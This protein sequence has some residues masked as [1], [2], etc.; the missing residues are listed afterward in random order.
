M[1]EASHN[2]MEIL[3][4]EGKE[5]PQ[6]IEKPTTQ[7]G[8]AE[9]LDPFFYRGEFRAYKSKDL[10]PKYENLLER[11]IKNA[12]PLNQWA[13][14]GES[15][16]WPSWLP[17]KINAVG[18]EWPDFNNDPGRFLITLSVMWGLALSS[19]AVKNWSPG[20]LTRF[21]IASTSKVFTWVDDET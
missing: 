2:L 15:F 21:E 6:Q 18:I 13:A 19:S 10:H 1:I 14:S 7:K 17:V 3:N 20:P 16:K 4:G 8:E 9:K 11:I 12:E 5:K